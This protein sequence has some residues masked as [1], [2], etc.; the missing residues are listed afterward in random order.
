[1]SIQLALECKVLY[2]Y[3]GLFVGPLRELTTGNTMYRPRPGL[4]LDPKGRV[5]ALATV[6]PFRK[7]RIL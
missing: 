5:L 7:A 1:M 4:E 6:C 2:N 3:A